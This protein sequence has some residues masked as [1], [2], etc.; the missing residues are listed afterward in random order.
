MFCLEANDV[1]IV[2]SKDMYFSGQ[3]SRGINHEGSISTSRINQKITA[4]YRGKK[5]WIWGSIGSQS[6]SALIYI[7][8]IDNFAANVS[9]YRSESFTDVYI[10]ESPELDHGYHKISIANGIGQEIS[11]SKL[12]YRFYPATSSFSFSSL[13]TDSDSYTPSN[14]FTK[15]DSYSP[16]AEFSISSHHSQLQT[17]RINLLH[18]IHLVHPINWHPPF[19]FLNHATFSHQIYSAHRILSFSPFKSI[20]S[21]ERNDFIK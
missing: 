18:R 12:I 21:I 19:N 7:D 17:Y 1:G 20:Y 14:D 8:S 2:Y 13:F 10:Y 11:I 9:L 15:S 16:S 3:W 4:H 6:G 5:F